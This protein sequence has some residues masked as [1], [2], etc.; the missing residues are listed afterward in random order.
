MRADYKRCSKAPPSV[1]AGPRPHHLPRSTTGRRTRCSRARSGRQASRRL[2]VGVGEGV[3]PR[4]RLPLAERAADVIDRVV[5]QR[6]AWVAGPRR[7]EVHEP[8][9]A[10]VKEAGAGAALPVDLAALEDLALE[11]LR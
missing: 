11:V 4:A 9:L 2:M 5:G 1:R 6:E 7:A 10:D 3:E 8:A